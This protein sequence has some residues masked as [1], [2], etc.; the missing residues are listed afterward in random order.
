MKIKHMCPRCCVW[1][2]GEPGICF[3][4]QIM[5]V[6]MDVIRQREELAASVCP[7]GD[8]CKD[9]KCILARKEIREQGADWKRAYGNHPDN[10]PAMSLVK[11]TEH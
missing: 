3:N 11:I 10:E 5:M 2:I 7:D 8:D 9:E 6:P 4:C 1:S